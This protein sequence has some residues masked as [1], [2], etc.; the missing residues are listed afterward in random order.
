[1]WLRKKKAAQYAAISEKQLERW[2]K[3]GLLCYKVDSFNLFHPNDIDDF[4]RTHHLNRNKTK[5]SNQI[6]N[7]MLSQLK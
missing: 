1:M 7:Q 3:R 5:Q 2:V 4:I 6:V